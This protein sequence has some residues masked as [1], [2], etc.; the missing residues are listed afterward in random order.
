VTVSPIIAEM[1]GIA[2]GV[3]LAAA[4]ITERRALEH[5]LVQ[6]QKLESIGQLAAGIAHEINT[7]TQYVGDNLHFLDVAFRSTSRMCALYEDLLKT[8]REAGFA[9]D[10]SRLISEA[11][12]EEDFGYLVNEIPGAIAQ[13]L[14]GVRRVAQIV[15]AM[16]E[17]S[18]PGSDDKA[19][20][21]LN[22]AIQSTIIVARN[23]WKYVAE[24]E[25]DFAP[26]LPLV[27]CF[28]GDFNQVIL[29]LLVN[30]AHAIAGVVGDGSRGKGRIGVGTRRVEEW[31]E[32]RVA[33]TGMGIPE[34]IRS[35]VFDPF[36]TTKEVGR[37][38]GQG[39]AISHGVI[40]KK[41]GGSI[42]FETEEGS[43]TTFIIRIPLDQSPGEEV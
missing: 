12:E 15:Q 20:I 31:A 13:S 29:N 3:L 2:S 23:E 43:G 17:F 39:L 18:H 37:G 28:P 10:L 22:K 8:C 33:D 38:T 16:K 27:P 5:Q 30:A 35:R 19:L 41:H 26:D 25:T 6:A 21:D 42:S 40:V 32:I 34:G 24:V 36:F 9:D 11:S 1:S 4:D 7:P 14:E